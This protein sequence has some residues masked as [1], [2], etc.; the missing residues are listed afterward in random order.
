MGREIP[1]TLPILLGLPGHHFTRGSLGSPS[2]YTKR[3]L[4]WFSHFST[5]LGCGQQIHT[6]TDH[7]TS[8][9]CSNRPHLRIAC[10]RR[11]RKKLTSCYSR[12]HG[13]QRPHR[14]SPLANKV[15]NIC[16]LVPKYDPSKV[17]LP[18]CRSQPPLNTW[19]L[20][21]HPAHIRDGRTIGSTVF[22]RYQHTDRQTTLQR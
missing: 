4:N 12:L 21:P 5:T 2:P 13:S 11:S 16:R 20:G 10:M 9:L 3:Y 19:F 15:E 7:A 17:P 8:A 1:P 14:C 22:A 18:A 6:H